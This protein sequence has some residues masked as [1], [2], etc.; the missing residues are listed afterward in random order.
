[1]AHQGFWKCEFSPS[2]I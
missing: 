2:L 1:M